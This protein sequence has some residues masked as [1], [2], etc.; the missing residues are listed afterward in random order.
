M[1]NS[2]SLNTAYM[3]PYYQELNM[4][5]SKWVTA[6]GLNFTS[7]GD[8]TWPVKWHHYLVEISHPQFVWF[9]TLSLTLNFT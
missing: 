5:Q 3:P 9:C 4:I 2:N 6:P 8:G 1:I 7:G